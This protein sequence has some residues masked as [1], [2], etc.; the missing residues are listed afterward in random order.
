VGIF[1]TAGV[2][3]T[4]NCVIYVDVNIL[5]LFS[6]ELADALL[7]PLWYIPSIHPSYLKGN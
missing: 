2:F 6:F 1:A 5:F 4:L 7:P 3:A